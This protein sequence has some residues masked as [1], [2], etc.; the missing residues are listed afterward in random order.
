MNESDEIK[1]NRKIIYFMEED[2]N[3]E[4]DVSECSLM[5]LILSLK[6]R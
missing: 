1:L 5:S 2:K 4:K 6:N 3:S